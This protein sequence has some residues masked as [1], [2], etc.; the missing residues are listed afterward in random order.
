MP[1][2]DRPNFPISQVIDLL[3]HLLFS[4]NELRIETSRSV[5]DEIS[6]TSVYLSSV[7]EYMYVSGL[8]MYE[9]LSQYQEA[10]ASMKELKH[11]Q[12]TKNLNY[13]RLKS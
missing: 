4:A 8:L 13:S 12:E 10:N 6:S 2:A 9:D 3:P 11:K 7:G 5:K 1:H